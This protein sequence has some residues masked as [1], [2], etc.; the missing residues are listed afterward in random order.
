MVETLMSPFMLQEFFVGNSQN[1]HRLLHVDSSARRIG[2]DVK[3]LLERACFEINL[4]LG[5]L[6]LFL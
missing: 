4:T 2:Y 5:L 6:H 1:A 3:T